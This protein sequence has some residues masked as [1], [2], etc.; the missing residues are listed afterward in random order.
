MTK[1]E[2]IANAKAQGAS[3]EELQIL[4]NTPDSEYC[5]VPSVGKTSDIT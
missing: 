3:E 1:D 4:R 5:N 2:V